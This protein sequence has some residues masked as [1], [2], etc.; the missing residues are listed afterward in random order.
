MTTAPPSRSLFAFLQHAMMMVQKTSACS[1]GA[2]FFVVGALAWPARTDNSA[3]DLLH[4][5]IK[6][7]ATMRD[8]KEHGQGKRRG[9]GV[10][11]EEERVAHTHR[12]T[13]GGGGSSDGRREEGWSKIEMRRVILIEAGECCWE[14]EGRG[15][16]SSN[17]TVGSRR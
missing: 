16:R 14:D 6:A 4:S 3:T 1:L 12:G 13:A 10:P 17:R 8:K 7:S 11:E 5:G 2:P 15:Q 9:E